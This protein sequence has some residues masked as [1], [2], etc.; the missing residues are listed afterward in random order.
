MIGCVH[1]ESN[2]RVH[3]ESNHQDLI[4]NGVFT[5]EEKMKMRA[6]FMPPLTDQQDV[7]VKAIE[8]A[9]TYPIS[10]AE[11]VRAR[12]NAWRFVESV[13]VC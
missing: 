2:H 5:E 10:Y 8:E 7:K 12:R 9:E 6:D 11:Q 3:W 4:V 1:W 13:F